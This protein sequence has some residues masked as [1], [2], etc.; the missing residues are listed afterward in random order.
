MFYIF[1]ENQILLNFKFNQTKTRRTFLCYK[2]AFFSFKNI[3]GPI[4]F[5]LSNIKNS[6]TVLSRTSILVRPTVLRRKFYTFH[7]VIGISTSELTCI[8]M[9]TLMRLT[10]SHQTNY[11][12]NMKQNE[13]NS[14]FYLFFVKASKSNFSRWIFHQ[15]SQSDFFNCSQKSVEI[16]LQSVKSFDKFG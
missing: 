13:S 6:L 5:F 12:G 4:H 7:S 2:S 16:D 3:Y 1:P 10:I 14:N 11:N 9:V 15:P 8:A